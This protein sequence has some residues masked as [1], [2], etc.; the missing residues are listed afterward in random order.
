MLANGL[1]FVFVGELGAA[2]SMMIMSKK[3]IFIIFIVGRAEI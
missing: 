3:N 2:G 1:R